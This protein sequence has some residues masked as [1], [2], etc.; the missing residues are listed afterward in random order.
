MTPQSIGLII[1]NTILARDRK[2]CQ[3]YSPNID[4]YFLK[5]NYYLKLLSNF[6]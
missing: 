6:I 1:M 3:S 4:G 2:N 5:S